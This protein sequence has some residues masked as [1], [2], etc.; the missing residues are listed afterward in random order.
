VTGTRWLGLDAKCVA[1]EERQNSATRFIRRG[2]ALTSPVNVNAMVSNRRDRSHTKGTNGRTRSGHAMLATVR[3]APHELSSCYRSWALLYPMTKMN[4]TDNQYW[5][6]NVPTVVL[7]SQ[8]YPSGLTQSVADNV[9]HNVQTLDGYG[10]FHGW[11]LFPR[12]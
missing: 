4:A 10:S 7:T 3:C 12:Q 8:S 6:R 5:N 1:G 2:C 9:D 11:A